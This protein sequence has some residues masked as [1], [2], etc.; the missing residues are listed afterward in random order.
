MAVPVEV[1]ADAKVQ[2]PP[3]FYSFLRALFREREPSIFSQVLDLSRALL[4]PLV[5]PVADITKGIGPIG[6]R[7]GPS[8]RPDATPAPVAAPFYR[9]DFWRRLVRYI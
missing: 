6:P 2:R 5:S 8:R 4:A 3:F 1:A 7:L 9:I